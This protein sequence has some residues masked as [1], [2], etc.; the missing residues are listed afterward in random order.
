MLPAF[1][2]LTHFAKYFVGKIYRSLHQRLPGV[3][4]ISKCQLFMFHIVGED[5][6]RT[7]CVHKCCVGTCFSTGFSFIFF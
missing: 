2:L 7:L 3:N 5:L 4:W 1:C 6:S